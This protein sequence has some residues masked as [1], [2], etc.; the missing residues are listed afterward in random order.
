MSSVRGFIFIR[1]ITFRRYNYSKEG[2]KS[3]K[4]RLTRQERKR[5]LSNRSSVIPKKGTVEVAEGKERA[6]PAIDIGRKGGSAVTAYRGRRVEV[7]KVK[8]S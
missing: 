2:R 7:I 8:G 3:K 5:L 1:L 6:E 4:R